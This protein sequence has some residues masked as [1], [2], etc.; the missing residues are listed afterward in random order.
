MKNRNKI[1]VLVI[2]FLLII[3]FRL[4][5]S[6]LMIKAFNI[7]AQLEGTKLTSDIL[8]ANVI[9]TKCLYN[10]FLSTLFVLKVESLMREVNGGKY[11]DRYDKEYN[12][13]YGVTAI[14]MIFYICY[15]F[16][17][18]QATYQLFQIIHQ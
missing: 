1:L 13:M 16:F 5:I 2:I 10:A 9:L 4:P 6:V 7:I 12:S 3:P 15:L 8:V 17:D 14:A 18:A 11:Y